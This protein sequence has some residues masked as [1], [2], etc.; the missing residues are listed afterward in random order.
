MRPRCSFYSSTSA[1]LLNAATVHT[2][3]KPH[4]SLSSVDRKVI[5]GFSQ[6]DI[7]AGT[8]KKFLKKIVEI[9][10]RER[11]TAIGVPKR[12]KKKPRKTQDEVE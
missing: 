4:M 11:P 1:P 2:H 8:V 5:H 10:Q 3:A 9:Q 6:L 7:P 12:A